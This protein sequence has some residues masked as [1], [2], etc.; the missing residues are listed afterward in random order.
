MGPS[1]TAPLCLTSVYQDVL[2]RWLPTTLS[3]RPFRLLGD[4]RRSL[5][6]RAAAGTSQSL[7]YQ[8]SVLTDTVDGIIDWGGESQSLLYQGSVLTAE[9]AEY[10]VDEESQSL[11]Y[12]GSVLTYIVPSSFPV[13]EVSIPSLSGLR[14]N[15][16]GCTACG[17]GESQSLLYQGSVLTHFTSG[18][19]CVRLQSQSLLYQ[20]SVLTT[21]RTKPC[22]WRSASQSLL[23]Q[24]SVLTQ[25]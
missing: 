3:T 23:Y 12:Q 22:W 25:P 19:S 5:S 17:C 10:V 24:G 2:Q 16:C 21:G 13:E 9:C 14:S 11:L 15:R 1:S 6:A 7:L 18:A 4:S 20:G 8:G